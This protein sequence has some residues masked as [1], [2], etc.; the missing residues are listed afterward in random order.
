MDLKVLC[1]TELLVDQPVRKVTAEG[2]GGGF[3]LLPN[4]GDYVAVLPAGLLIFESITGE[5]HC[6]AIDEGILVKQG[7][8]VWVSVRN[9]V[10]GDNLD[11]LQ[12]AV[13]AQF[14]QLDEQEER[15]R[16]ML[17]RLESS[18]VRDFID[19]GGAL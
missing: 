3:C 1:L 6:L 18:I 14:T 11:D 2:D 16:S 8:A 9:A 15:A 19:L 7:A 4:H 17:T 13:Q 5:E 10:R 12:Q